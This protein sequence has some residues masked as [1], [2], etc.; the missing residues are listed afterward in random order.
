MEGRWD[1]RARQILVAV[2]AQDAVVVA[3]W[4]AGTWKKKGKE[5]VE[6]QFQGHAKGCTH[7]AYFGCVRDQK[8]THML[9]E[10]KCGGLGRTEG[11][12]QSS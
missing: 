3:P 11:M 1:G 8:P 2:C 10:Q 9:A 12:D 5:W 7:S 4:S 6:G